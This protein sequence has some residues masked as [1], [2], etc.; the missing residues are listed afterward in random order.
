MIAPLIKS[1]IQTENSDIRAHVSVVGKCV[2][3]FQTKNGVKAARMSRSIKEGGQPGYRGRTFRGVT[4]PWRSVEGIKRITH[5]NWSEWGRFSPSLDTSQKGKLA[6]EFVQCV[7]KGGAFPFWITAEEDNRREIQI[8]GT[9]LIV[10]SKIRIQVKCDYEAGEG[11]TGNLF[12]Q[13]AECNP[14]KKY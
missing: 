1:G 5:N 4:V 7:L 12:L 8:S 3:V 6:V 10:D 9:D 2:Y 14:F 11:G 13:T